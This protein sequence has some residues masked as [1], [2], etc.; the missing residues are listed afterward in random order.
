MVELGHTLMSNHI[1]NG[2]MLLDLACDHVSDIHT[3]DEAVTILISLLDYCGGQ[4]NN[5]MNHQRAVLFISLSTGS[6]CCITTG[7]HKIH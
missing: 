3:L 1:K 2:N 5:Q 6:G 4:V 7:C